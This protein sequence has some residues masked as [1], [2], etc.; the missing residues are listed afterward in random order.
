MVHSLISWSEIIGNAER[1]AYLP[2]H[3]NSHQHKWRENAQI[4]ANKASGM[5]A[6]TCVVP[7]A[8]LV[9]NSMVQCNL[10]G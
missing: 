1:S 3:G 10:M 5:N 2:S 6:H 4:Q 9:H 8:V 7:G